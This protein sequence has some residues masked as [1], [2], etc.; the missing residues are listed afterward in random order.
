MAFSFILEKM[1]F[2]MGQYH[3]KEGGGV[4]GYIHHSQALALKIEGQP[5]F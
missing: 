1:I 3:K 4:C 5:Y 2:K